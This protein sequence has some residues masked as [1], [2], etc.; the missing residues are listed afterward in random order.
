MPTLL[1]IALLAGAP[2]EAGRDL[3]QDAIARQLVI[4][5]GRAALLDYRPSLE[6]GCTPTSA[7]IDRRIAG[8]G[9]VAVALAGED[10]HGRP[11]RGWAWARVRVVAS[12]IVA[13]RALSPGDGLEGATLREER[14]ILAGRA[15]VASLPKGAKAAQSLSAGQL[16]EA[17]HLRDP[18]APAPGEAIAVLVQRGSIAVALE[19][20]AVPCP[21]GRACA[22]LPN[23][24]RLE[25]N[26][27]DRRLVVEIP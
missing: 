16:V 9:R 14:E 17:V 13:A 2:G 25:G 6:A 5:G 4:A 24:R 8:S 22:Q 7:T 18:L 3:S 11:C 20:H 15:P 10:L 21:R 26:F 27:V 19:G 1:F 12:V 23:G